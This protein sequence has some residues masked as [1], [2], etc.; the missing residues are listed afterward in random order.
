MGRILE[1]HALR[2]LIIDDDKAHGESLSDLLN[3]RGHEAY[4]APSLAEALWLLDLF[5]FDLALLDYDMP[6]NSGPQIAR[7]LI[8]F[9]SRLRCVVM[10]AR[11]NDDTRQSELGNLPFMSKPISTDELFELLMDAM[12]EAAGTSLVVRASFP[13]VR[14]D[15]RRD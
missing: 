4:F 13:L 12:A 8:A 3:T 5:A 2:L 7:K 6:E 15:P 14:Y 1:A 10:S 9:D 11:E